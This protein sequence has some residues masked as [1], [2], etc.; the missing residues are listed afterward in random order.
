MVFIL[1]LQDMEGYNKV[2]NIIED[3]E[4]LAEYTGEIRFLPT[5]TNIVKIEVR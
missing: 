4:V 3:W 2:V 5:S 1:S